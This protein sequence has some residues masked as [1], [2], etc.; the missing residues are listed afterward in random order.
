MRAGDTQALPLARRDQLVVQELP[1]ELLVYDLDR[2]KAHCLNQASA[3]VWKHCDGKTTMAEMTRLLEREL[4]TSVDDDVVW[5]ALSQ[6]RRFHLLE[7]SKMVGMMKVSRRDLVQKY[8]P[9]AL[10][11]P[12]ILSIP[13]PIA[14][15]AGSV[16]CGTAG[17]SCSNPGD[18]PCCPGFGCDGICF[19]R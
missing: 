2:H 15:Q 9:A 14:A 1:D 10:I 8:L 6:L 3:I 5:L 18:P 12:V 4:G 13:A 19:P 17:A 16:P 7:E 11:L